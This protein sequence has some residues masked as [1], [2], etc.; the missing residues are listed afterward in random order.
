MQEGFFNLLSQNLRYTGFPLRL[1]AGKLFQKARPI[2][3][4]GEALGYIRIS[5]L[6]L[7]FRHKPDSQ[8][9]RKSIGRILKKKNRNI[10]VIIDDLDRLDSQELMEVFKLIRSVGSIPRI[11]YLL[12]YDESVILQLLANSTFIKEINGIEASNYLEKIVQVT[13]PVPPL[14]DGQILAVFDERLKLLTEA[15]N[16][17]PDP[18]ELREL[19]IFFRQSII[20]H[21]ATPRDLNRFFLSLQAEFPRSPREFNFADLVVLSWCKHRHPRL[22]EAIKLNKE[23]N[24]ESEW[25]KEFTNPSTANPDSLAQIARDVLGFCMRLALDE[26]QPQP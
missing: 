12:S 21:I 26:I 1:R 15:M 24:Q 8:K 20:K 7:A 13:F 3:A 9:L 6:Q 17:E 19:E 16:F 11:H 22:H 10:L 23:C 18:T 2:L 25:Q 5:S 14:R 4:L